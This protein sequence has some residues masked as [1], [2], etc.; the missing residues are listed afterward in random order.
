MSFLQKIFNPPVHVDSAKEGSQNL[1]KI[2]LHN[3]LVAIFVI[4]PI[5]FISDGYVTAVVSASV[6]GIILVCLY[7]MSHGYLSAA[8]FNSVF[9]FLLTTMFTMFIGYGI[10]LSPKLYDIK[11]LFISGYTENHFS[12]EDIAK[13]KINYLLKPFSG[14]ELM[15]KVGEI[16]DK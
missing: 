3:S 7:L 8:S 15:I 14:K 13:R 11:I 16:L 9:T 4:T 1:L 6:F 10:E 5:S 12:N 2:V